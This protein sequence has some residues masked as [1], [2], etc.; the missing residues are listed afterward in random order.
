MQPSVPEG[1]PDAIE[2]SPGGLAVVW[3]EENARDSIFEALSRREAYGTSGTRPEVRFFGGWE[4]PEDMCEAAN[5]A[6]QGYALGVPMGG[7]LRSRPADLDAAVGPTF[8]VSALQDP[9]TERRP[10]TALQRIQIVKGWTE[11]GATHEKVYDVAGGPN[12][13]SVDLNSC[14]PLGAGARSLCQVWRDP[15]FDPNESAFYY[16]RVLENPTC[17]WQQHLCVD[18][19]VDCADPASIGRGYAACCDSSVPRTIQE[20]AWTSPIWY[21]SAKESSP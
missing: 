10:G 8:V 2:F 9:G 11:D 4:Y 17:R 12:D 15:N 19:K 6:E 7:D 20:R 5:L 18:A 1:L 21:A 3:A 13:A 14:T 16:A